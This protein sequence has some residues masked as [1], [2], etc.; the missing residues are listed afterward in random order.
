MKFPRR[1]LIVFSATLVLLIAS[2]FLFSTKVSAES[3]NEPVANPLRQNEP[4]IEQQ[5]QKVAQKASELNNASQEIQDLEAKKQ[6]LF[7]QLDSIKQETSDLQQKLADKKAA[8]E[9]AKKR[10]VELKN[11]FVHVNVYAGDSSGNLY[12]PGNCTWYAKSRRPDLPNNLGNANTWYSMAASMGW[13]VGSTPKKGA[14]ATTT[15]GWAGHVA[16]VEGVSP[17]GLRVTI[18]EMNWNG[19]Y[20]MNTRTVNYTEFRY[21][22]E[23][24]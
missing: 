24:N 4:I 17:D 23:L 3:V 6:T 9:A 2:V 22:Y 13:N 18:S 10:V 19:L 12:T 20:S 5:S 8:A 11:M 7:Q 14:V 1:S 16:Y 21:I 15:A